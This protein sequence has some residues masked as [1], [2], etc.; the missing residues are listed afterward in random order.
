[1]KK[2]DPFKSLSRKA[3][4]SECGVSH[5]VRQRRPGWC[6]TCDIRDCHD[7]GQS[8]AVIAVS[9]DL[10]RFLIEATVQG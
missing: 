3:K 1:M 10:P 4:C 2:T 9:L 7:K 8:V 5:F 6:L